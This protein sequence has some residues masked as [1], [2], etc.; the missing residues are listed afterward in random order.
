MKNQVI[1][2]KTA[3]YD[4]MGNA[5]EECV[6]PV[7]HRME[8]KEEFQRQ[9]MQM[10]SLQAIVIGSKFKVQVRGFRALEDLN[11]RKSFEVFTDAIGNSA[12]WEIMVE[13]PENQEFSESNITAAT[14][15]AFGAK[16]GAENVELIEL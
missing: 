4:R 10:D 15:T 6:I 13:L 12:V 7:L 14:I 8:P 1:R 3:V 11:S 2:I 5:Y 9:G 16:F